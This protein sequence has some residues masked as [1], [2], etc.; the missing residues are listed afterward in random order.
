MDSFYLPS[1]ATAKARTTSTRCG[2]HSIRRDPGDCGEGE[3]CP[4]EADGSRIHDEYQESKTGS[5]KDVKNEGTSGDVYE[6]KGK[7]KIEIGTSGDVD[8]NTEVNR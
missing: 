2:A 8:E 6:N 1:G 4:C 7:L 3:P 5:R